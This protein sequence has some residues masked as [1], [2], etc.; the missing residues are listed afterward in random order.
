MGTAAAIIG[1]AVVSGIA[2]SS[3]ASKAAKAQTNA[4]NAQI[5]LQQ[6]QFNRV[7]ELLSPYVEA[8][9][10]ALQGQLNLI[11]LGGAQAQQDAINALATSPQM[12][13]LTQQGEM[14]I[15]QNASATGGLRGGNTQAALAQFRPQ[16]LS[17]LINQQYSQLGGLSQLGQASAAGVGAA[18]QNYANAA[19]TAYG[20]IANAQAGTALAQSQAISG[21]GSSLAN[22]QL[23][24]AMGLFGGGTGGGVNMSNAVTNA[25]MGGGYTPYNAYSL[26][27]SL[28]PTKV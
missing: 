7:Q 22:Y 23:M 19:G 25:A 12:E 1:S 18:G 6:E 9:D 8:G 2:S 21:V 4:S 3:A 10:T 15:L 14:G 20:N 16:V 28:L 5:A 27:S 26:P 24:N 13:A 11:G 17:D